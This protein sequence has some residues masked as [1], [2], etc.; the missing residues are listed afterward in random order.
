[1]QIDKQNGDIAFNE[2]EHLYVNIKYPN[3]KYT[4][5]TTLISMYHEKFDSE[6]WSSY[7]ALE[8]IMGIETFKSTVKKALLD[9]KCFDVIDLN[10]IGV[11]V[12]H[13]LKV[14]N[15]ILLS[16]KL[17]NEQACERGT[18]Y[19]TQKEDALYSTPTIYIEELNLPIPCKGSY[20]CEKHNWDLNEEYKILPEYLIYYSSPDGILNLAGQ[21]DLIVKEGNDLYV[22]DYKTNAKGIEMN[23][24]YDRKKKRSKMMFF[25]LNNMEDC[26]I[27]HYTLQLSLYAWMLKQINPDFNIKGLTI[28]HVD[29]NG[30]ETSYPINY[31]EKEVEALL[32]HYKKGIVVEQR[33]STGK[34]SN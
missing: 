18:I 27:Q 11:N 25:P 24:Y 8:Q 5:V 29:G 12:P 1:M 19:H 33:R 26:M 31:V 15:D 20:V 14:K 7:K 30:I 2:A 4:S 32:K 28:L 10:K 23:S 13:F 17:A 34:M 6:F 21:V 16:Y 3:R 9:F 22:L